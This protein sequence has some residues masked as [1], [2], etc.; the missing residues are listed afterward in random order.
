MFLRHPHNT[1][2]RSISHPPVSGC[3]T[4]FLG[5]GNCTGV[6]ERLVS[7]G[8]D[9]T[10][11]RDDTDSLL[12]LADETGGYLLEVVGGVVSCFVF[13]LLSLLL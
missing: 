2:P 6:D 8:V 13:L 5:E 1:P 3:I 9:A 11:F 12:G 4:G 10:N 7:T